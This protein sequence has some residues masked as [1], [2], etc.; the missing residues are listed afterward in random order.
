[1]RIAFVIDKLESGGTQRQLVTLGAPFM[2]RGYD[3]KTFVYYWN[4]FFADDLADAG[5]PVSYVPFHNKAHLIC[6]MR[7]AIKAYDPDVV[8]SYLPGPNALMGLAGLPRRKYALISSEQCLDIVGR[9]RKS[10]VR[11]GFHFLAD[12]VVCNSQSQYRHILKVFPRLKDRAFVIDN[13]VNLEKFLPD[14]PPP[15]RP[16]ELRVLVL[17]RVH[18]QKNPFKLL[19]AVDIIRQE[20]PQL[21][22]S[23]DWYGDTSLQKVAYHAQLKEAIERRSLKEVFRLHSPIKNVVQLYHETDVV[24][25]PS[26]YEGTPNV[27]CEAMACGIP[28]LVSKIVDNFRLVEEGQTGLLFDPSSARDIADTILQFANKPYEVRR[29]M[30][31]MGRKRAEILL[32]SDSA[33]DRYIKLIREILDKRRNSLGDVL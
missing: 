31:I 14:K 1:M 24:C 13:G 6:A 17:A 32:S 20:Q 21:S 8:L 3:V 7:K 19:E 22:V 25:L 26:L 18:P 12:A 33:V 29:E 16:G 15:N 9:R 11:Y 27:V 23:V 28:V 10:F 2:D 30:G 4:D 5:I